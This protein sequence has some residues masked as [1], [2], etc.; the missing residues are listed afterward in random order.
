MEWMSALAWGA[1]RRKGVSH[2]ILTLLLEAKRP[3]NC[4]SPNA[5]VRKGVGPCICAKER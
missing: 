3:G 5:R 1:V 4:I 2:L